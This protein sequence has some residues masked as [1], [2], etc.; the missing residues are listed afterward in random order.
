MPSV[1]TETEV[2]VTYLT[3]E[4][5]EIM[6]KTEGAGNSYSYGRLF[7]TDIKVRNGL[8]LDEVY[9]YV[10]L[11]GAVD[12]DGTIAALAE[13]PA[14]NRR[15]T[16]FTQRQALDESRKMICPYMEL[17]DFIVSDHRRSDIP[18]GGIRDAR[19]IGGSV[20]VR[21]VRAAN[22]NLP[23]FLEVKLPRFLECVLAEPSAIMICETSSHIDGFPEMNT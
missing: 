10:A 1:G 8:S 23:E 14:S 17:H 21:K 18:P 19:P 6:H 13:I 7:N 9:T 4:Q 12:F 2:F 20:R 22:L 15:F 11:P 5:L 3:D 16:S